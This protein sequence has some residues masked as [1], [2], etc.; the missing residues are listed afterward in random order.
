MWIVRLV[1]GMYAIERSHVCVCD[2]Y[3][4]EFEVKIGIHQDSV[5]SLLLF[6]IV[7]EAL[8][9]EFCSGVPCEDLYTNDLVIM[10]NRSR[11]VSR[12]S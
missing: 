3:S 8:P 9:R 2:G 7:F 11:N 1:Q 4:E 10:L 12:G 6:I 5:L